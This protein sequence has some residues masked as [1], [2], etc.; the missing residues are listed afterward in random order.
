[1]VAFSLL[2]TLPV[3]SLVAATTWRRLWAK[4]IKRRQQPHNAGHD[5]NDM[6]LTC[7]AVFFATPLSHSVVSDDQHDNEEDEE[8]GDHRQENVNNEMHSSDAVPPPS[9]TLPQS[10]TAPKRK[11]Y[12]RQRSRQ[13]RANLSQALQQHLSLQ[14]RESS[15]S[16]LLT[17]IYS[18]FFSSSGDVASAATATK[19]SFSAQHQYSPVT[20]EDTFRDT[21]VADSEPTTEE[22]DRAT[23]KSNC[24]FRS[25]NHSRSREN[26]LDG[27]HH[28]INHSAVAQSP[29]PSTS[30][31]SKN[32]RMNNSTAE[33]TT[34]TNNNSL[35]NSNNTS[36]LA[37]RVHST[38]LLPK[39]DD[40]EE[41]TAENSHLNRSRPVGTSTGEALYDQ[42]NMLL[43][44]TSPLPERE[45]VVPTLLLWLFTIVIS[46]FVK[47][48]TYL[49]GSLGTLSTV[50]LLFIIPA[51][52]YQRLRLVSDYESIPLYGAI[53]PNHVYMSVLLVI[54]VLILFFDILVDG[55][56]FASGQRMFDP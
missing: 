37:S 23:F 10:P 7:C 13:S 2:L 56:F 40:D 39:E 46:L 27:E 25:Y 21:L 53:L 38:L 20:Q 15:S 51:L 26:S 28:P 45:Q 48:W 52:L 34:N 31:D 11:A 1:M 36:S 17:G 42:Y 12:H 29:H 24:S 5:P 22:T 50:L 47:D 16:S 19:T 30:S 54:G 49:A 9:T 43:E 32:K 6:E 4:L 55:Y 35:T 8:A 41:G 3:D 44:V 14:Q 33:D 18:T